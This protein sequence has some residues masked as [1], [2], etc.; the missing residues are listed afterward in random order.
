MPIFKYVYVFSKSCVALYIAAES[1]AAKRHT[2]PAPNINGINTCFWSG[3]STN[4]MKC[5]LN[6]PHWKINRTWPNDHLHHLST[7]LFESLIFSIIFFFQKN[8]YF[9]SIIELVYEKVSFLIEC[10]Q[11]VQFHLPCKIL[12]YF[13]QNR[14][15]YHSHLTEDI[16]QARFYVLVN[17]KDK[18]CD[19][20]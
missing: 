3:I 2:T 4:K 1:V 14:D 19:F 7:I 13:Y 6:Y 10:E 9:W 8:G 17:Q 12:N 20:L 16:L 15:N 11:L 5:F 18:I